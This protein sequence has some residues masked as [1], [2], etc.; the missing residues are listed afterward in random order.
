ME[1]KNVFNCPPLC[2]KCNK[3]HDM[4]KACDSKKDSNSEVKKRKDY[5][6]FFVNEEG[7]LEQLSNWTNKENAEKYV[8]SKTF[9]PKRKQVILQKV[10]RYWN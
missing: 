2:G 9:F 5:A 4:N 3:V 6:T 1:E 10:S 8:G 7:E